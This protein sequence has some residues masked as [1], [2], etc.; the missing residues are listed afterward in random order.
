M[1]IGTVKARSI[2]IGLTALLIAVSVT[3]G[4]IEASKISEPKAAFTVV[5]DAGHGGV[6]GGVTG[7][8][9]GVKES[10][11]N[12]EM[13]KCLEECFK[14]ADVNV[15]MTRKNKSGLYDSAEEKNFKR[16]DFY[17]RRDIINEARP[18]LVL[19]IHMNF[20]R[21]A[22]YRRGAQVF[23]NPVS[24]ESRTLAAD[25]QNKL[26]TE[27]NLKYSKRGYASLSGDYFI[28][29]CT[30]YPS[31]IVE[32]GFLSNAEDDR[33]LN[34]DKYRAEFSYHLFSACMQYLFTR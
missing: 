31:V 29:N 2:I 5:I 13:A 27:I 24:A 15:V 23:F 18:D 3:V 30:E 34:T 21:G 26:N 25:I 28:L 14:K 9:S 22:P 10:D 12:L 16:K 4:V 11:L 32:C 19:S 6:D 20:Y 7:I 17:K 33:L 1:K 8:E